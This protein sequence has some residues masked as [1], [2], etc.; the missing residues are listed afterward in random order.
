MLRVSEIYASYQGEG[1]NTGKPTVF[2]RFAGCNLRC[3]GWPCDTQHA[4]DPK[5]FT[6]EQKLYTP[7]DLA[8]H[9]IDTYPAVNNICYTGGEVFI[10]SIDD[11]ES[12]MD[13]LAKHHTPELTQECFTNGTREIPLN[14][15]RLL[16]TVVLDWKLPGSG[17]KTDYD[18][19]SIVMQNINHLRDDDA[20]KFTVKDWNDYGNARVLWNTIL[21]MTS[22]GGVVYCGPVWGEIDSSELAAWMLKDGLP[23]RLNTQVHKYVWPADARGT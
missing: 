2:V 4:I 14:V 17:E 19:D 3:P 6:K 11:L 22:F 1:P 10:Q 15:W 13:Q 23:W 20:L 21:P 7:N 18:P 16:D 12:L 5:I 9:I 8:Q